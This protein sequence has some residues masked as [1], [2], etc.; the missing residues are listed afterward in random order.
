MRRFKFMAMTAMMGGV[1]AV[2]AGCGSNDTD[3]Q[4]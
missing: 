1:I 4:R 3:K 2:A